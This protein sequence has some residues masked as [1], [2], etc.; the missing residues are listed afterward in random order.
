MNE[1]EFRAETKEVTTVADGDLHGFRV[2]K[3]AKWFPVNDKCT[4]NH[5]AD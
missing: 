2:L 4:E 1:P 3:T 5:I